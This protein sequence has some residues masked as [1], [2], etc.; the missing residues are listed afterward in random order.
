MEKIHLHFKNVDGFTLLEVMISLVLVGIL[1]LGHMYL[2]G[3]I[4]VTSTSS[5]R[6]MVAGKM[7]ERKI[8]EL[9]IETATSDWDQWWQEGNSVTTENESGVTLVI[10]VLEEVE[11]AIDNVPAL[12][13]DD[14]IG[15]REVELIATWD[16]PKPETLRVVT[17]LAEGL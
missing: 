8:E 3:N 15:V 9:R 11:P 10:N 5:N 2:Q 7:I 17:Y 13:V 1:L 6:R 14:S 16:S 4:N 12:E